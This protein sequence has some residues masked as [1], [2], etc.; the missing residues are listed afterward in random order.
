MAEELRPRPSLLGT[1]LVAVVASWVVAEV[2]ESRSSRGTISVSGT[3][4]GVEL[5]DVDFT[6]DGSHVT[7]TPKTI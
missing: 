6:Q 7:V 3:S 1:F 5:F 2:R 4:V